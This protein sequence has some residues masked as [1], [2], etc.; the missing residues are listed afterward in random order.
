M[1][2]FKGV[3]NLRASDIPNTPV[4][5]AYIIIPKE[6]MTFPTL[7]IE[8]NRIDSNPAVKE[9][10]KDFLIKDYESILG[11]IR[12]ASDAGKRIWVSPSSSFSIYE[13]V[14]MKVKLITLK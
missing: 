12:T 8:R 5:F 7:Y 6:N 1:T 2:F 3:T 9:Y 11:D 10:L 14:S 13:A 4:F